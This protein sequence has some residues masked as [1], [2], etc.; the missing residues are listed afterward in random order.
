MEIYLVF[1]TPAVRGATASFRRMWRCNVPVSLRVDGR[2]AS[3]IK[4]AGFHNM[5]DG[6]TAFEEGA[7][8]RLVSDFEA[9]GYKVFVEGNYPDVLSSKAA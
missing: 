6:W 5:P 2:T 8:E 9:A 1:R 4:S 3:I 7:A